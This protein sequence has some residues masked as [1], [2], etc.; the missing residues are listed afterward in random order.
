[1]GF[2][3]NEVDCGAVQ[4]WRPRAEE[5]AAPR[6][7]RAQARRAR[8][9]RAFFRA[10][11]AVGHPPGF[12][13]GLRAKGEQ[14]TFSDV[15][16]IPEI[17]D[18]IGEN[19]TQ[20]HIENSTRIRTPANRLRLLDCRAP[21]LSTATQHDVGIQ[22]D[23]T[24]DPPKIVSTGPAMV[25]D[26]KP[27]SI[28]DQPAAA[29][30]AIEHETDKAHFG[31]V[32]PVGDIHV[33]IRDNGRRFKFADVASF[34][35]ELPR[36]KR[37]TSYS[38]KSAFAD[39][40]EE[41]RLADVWIHPASPWA[42]THVA[43]KVLPGC[44]A[45]LRGATAK[46]RA[47]QWLLWLRGPSP[48]PLML[49][50]GLVDGD[51]TASAPCGDRSVTPRDSE[52]A[53]KCA[54]RHCAGYVALRPVDFRADLDILPR[55]PL[56]AGRSYLRAI[57]DA[58]SESAAALP[59]PTAASPRPADTDDLQRLPTATWDRI[60]SAME[61]A[62][63]EWQ[64]PPTFHNLFSAH[65]A[66]TARAQEVVNHETAIMY[67][68]EFAVDRY[69]SERSAGSIREQAKS[70]HKFLEASLSI[71]NALTSRNPRLSARIALAR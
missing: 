39:L 7:T 19:F 44:T 66:Q 29:A 4:N 16:A 55:A 71:A 3:A 50:D 24:E 52:Y 32:Q 20:H 38:E 60:L 51:G 11:A 30:E 2:N 18:A 26:G 8:L 49:C 58:P 57:L 53:T 56:P 64:V 46:C 25:S 17:R 34:R 45:R 61:D 13:A 22:T 47:P 54:R 62:A 23:S 43:E 6:R 14:V 9:K 21:G 41:Y 27:G 15:L 48:I 1:M 70:I 68:Y 59:R 63:H 36:H 5:Q 69:D 31:S 65:L 67:A 33:G 40:G 28:S 12:E 42:C 37:D 35:A 10:G